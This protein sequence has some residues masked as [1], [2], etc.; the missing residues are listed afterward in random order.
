MIRD[1]CRAGMGEIEMHLHHENDTPESVTRIYRDG[2]ENFGRFG[3]SQTIDSPAQTRFAFVHGN[4]ALDNGAAEISP[5]PC[6]VNNELQILRS[7]GCFVDC[8]FPALW[9]PAQPQRINSIYY[10]TD[11]PAKPKSYDDG[12]PVE[13]GRAASGDLMLLQGPLIIDWKNWRH[14]THPTME[15]GDLSAA[16]PIYP[17]RIELWLRANIHVVGRPEWVFV[18]LHAHSMHRVDWPQ[19]IGQPFECLLQ[20]LESAYNDGRRFIMHYVTAR[21]S[22]N[23][24]KA[25]EAGQ[26]GDPNRYRDFVIPPYR[27]NRTSD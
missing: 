25:A 8:T 17:R 22:Y 3:I 26:S 20:L 1:L 7:L 16:S 12:V 23:I 18:K 5:N 10:A 14:R 19:V 6:G 11:D 13:A 24:I 21:E 27:A 9:S 15:H 4:W 2:L